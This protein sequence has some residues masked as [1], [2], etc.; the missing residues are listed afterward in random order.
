MGYASTPEE[1]AIVLKMSRRCDYPGWLLLELPDGRWA[2][3]WHAAIGSDYATGVAEGDYAGSCACISADKQVVLDYLTASFV[4][5]YGGDPKD[6]AKLL[7]AYQRESRE[8]EKRWAIERPKFEKKRQLLPMVSPRRV[9]KD[10][11]IKRN[12]ELAEAF[13]GDSSPFGNAPLPVLVD[14][15]R[16]ARA[17]YVQAWL[18]LLGCDEASFKAKAYPRFV[19]KIAAGSRTSVLTLFGWIANHA[20]E[21][22]VVERRAGVALVTKLLEQIDKGSSKPFG[23]DFQRELLLHGLLDTRWFT[24]LVE[25]MNSTD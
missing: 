8:H 17:A 1:D 5:E 3:L 20:A 10:A 11:V 7:R 2:A 18:A 12:A 25:A 14:K 23:A 9:D 6:I 16:E 21:L 24:M 22:D 4:R 13:W 15:S 19:A